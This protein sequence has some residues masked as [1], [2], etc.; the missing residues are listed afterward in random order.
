M[1]GMALVG[2]VSMSTSV[3]ATFCSSSS[4]CPGWPTVTA[5][6]YTSGGSCGSGWSNVTGSV[7]S[8]LY[9]ATGMA[10]RTSTECAFRVRIV[11][12]TSGNVVSD[13]NLNPFTFS[14]DYNTCGNFWDHTLILNTNGS[15]CPCLRGQKYQT[16]GTIYTGLTF[17]TNDTV[18]SNYAGEISTLSGATTAP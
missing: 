7:Y 16:K 12:G 9:G 6:G 3:M 8:R 14:C 2:V 10:M 1:F 15:A 17:G 5:P 13:S 4:N 11:N 18:A